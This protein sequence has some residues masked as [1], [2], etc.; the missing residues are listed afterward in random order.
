MQVLF[1]KLIELFA[2]YG[3]WTVFFGVMLENTGLPIPGETVLLAASFLAANPPEPDFVALKIQWVIAVAIIAA[4]M[5]DNIGYWIGA[6][7]GRPFIRRHARRFFIRQSHLD[8]AERIFQR[9]GAVTV[10]FARFITGLRVLAGPFAGILHLPWPRFFLFNLAGALV[11]ASTVGLIG[12][13][14]GTEWPVLLKILRR[15]SLA[16]LVLFFLVVLLI[17][18]RSRS[19]VEHGGK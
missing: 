5:G 7:G 14:F 9:Y 17:F 6:R 4:T 3:Y 19:K 2:H 8:Q 16:L 1:S 10:F 13:F 12:Y 15:F 18:L 11:W